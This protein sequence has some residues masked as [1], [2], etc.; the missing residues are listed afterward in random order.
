VPWLQAAHSVSFD[1]ADFQVE[2]A[3]FGSLPT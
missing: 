3:Y 1:A 2:E